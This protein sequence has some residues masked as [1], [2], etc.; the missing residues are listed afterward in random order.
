MRLASRG[1][2]AALSVFALCLGAAAARYPGGSWSELGSRG[3]SLSRNFWCDLL[4]SQAINGADN[5]ASRR[6][7]GL[8]FAALAFAL[9]C[10]WRPASELSV[11]P[12]QRGWVLS[13]G[14]ASTLVLASMALLPSD[15]YPV[16]HGLLALAGAAYAI[17]CVGICSA[18]RLP[19]ERSWSLRRVSGGAL[20]AFG[21]GNAGWYV[22]VAY[23]GGP[24]TLT[25]PVLQ[26][27]ATLSLLVWMLSTLRRAARPQ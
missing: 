23:L 26:K 14:R 20:L 22:Y 3:F 1:T 21:L 16:L 27:L 4:R 24:E 17:A 2:L 18:P 10:Y 7:S 5:G 8:A 25:Q 12:V 15:A 11:R 9:W 13:R 6:L 19:E